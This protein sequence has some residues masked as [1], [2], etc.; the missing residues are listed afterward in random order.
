[1]E[2]SKEG[3]VVAHA[4]VLIKSVVALFLYFELIEAA[5]R[6]V[7]AGHANTPTVLIVA[8]VLTRLDRL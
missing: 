2:P 1:M 6:A 7:V 4:R 8:L 5:S 3:F